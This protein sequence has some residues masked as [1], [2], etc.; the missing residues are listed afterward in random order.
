[1][2]V[3][4]SERW[5]C[6]AYPEAFCR[7]DLREPRP[8]RRRHRAARLLDGER[9]RPRRRHRRADDRH[10]TIRP[11]TSPWSSSAVSA[12]LLSCRCA[13]TTAARLHHCSI[14]RSPAVHRQADRAACRISRRRRSSR[15]RT[16]GYHRDARGAGAADRDRRGLAGHQFLARRPRAGVR[17]DVGKGASALCEAAYGVL[18]TYDGEHV[19]TSRAQCIAHRS[20]VWCGEPAFRPSPGSPSACCAGERLVHMHDHG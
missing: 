14:A 3:S 13:R 18:L 17:C 1:M 19:S 20:R 12:P 6:T 4:T 9:R 11:A 7:V 15:W 8:P 5:R 10:L 16:R 2:T